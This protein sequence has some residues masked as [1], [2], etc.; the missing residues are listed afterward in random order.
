MATPEIS[1]TFPIASIKNAGGLSRQDYDNMQKAIAEKYQKAIND[2]DKALAK[3]LLDAYKG[4]T[5]I[6]DFEE[7][8]KEQENNNKNII[9]IG[10]CCFDISECLPNQ[11]NK[12]KF[13]IQ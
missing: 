10:S 5:A 11:K 8:L 3:K 13:L 4:I 1:H 7:D 12:K 2:G 9:C 6:R